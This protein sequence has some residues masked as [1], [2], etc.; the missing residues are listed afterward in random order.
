MRVNISVIEAD[1]QTNQLNVMCNLT[2]G[3]KK[4]KKRRQNAV[5]IVLY[6]HVKT[7]YL[8]AVLTIL[9][10]VINERACN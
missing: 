4:K 9:Y 5:L 3:G 7:N 6:K 10:K 1:F 2:G 8:P